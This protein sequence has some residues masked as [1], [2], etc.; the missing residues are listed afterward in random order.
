MRFTPLLD[1]TRVRTE[2]GWAPGVGFGEGLADTR[3]GSVR[4]T[5]VRGRRPT[6]P[7]RIMT[8][9]ASSRIVSCLDRFTEV[10]STV[11]RTKLNSASTTPA[12][13]T[14]IDSRSGAWMTA[15][16]RCRGCCSVGISIAFGV[17]GRPA[18]RR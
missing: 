14:M 7:L 12:R 6:E 2:L 17:S 16:R 13:Q 3:P 15:S 10:V 9:P 1:S 18:T 11:S 5:Q 8:Y 4:A